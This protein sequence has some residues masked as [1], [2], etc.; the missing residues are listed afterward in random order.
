MALYGSQLKPSGTMSSNIFQRRLNIVDFVTKHGPQTLAQIAKRLGVSLSSVWRHKKAIEPLQRDPVSAFW[1]TTVG[2]KYLVQVFVAVIYCFGIKQGV[3][4]ERLSEFFRLVGLEGHVATSPSALRDFKQQLIEHIN[5]YGKEQGQAKIPENKPLIGGADETFFE[6]PILVL[7]ELASGYIF[8]EV[9][10]EKRSFE[11][12]TE[13]VEKV[14]LPPMTA[15]VSDGARAL[16]KLAIDRLRCIHLPDLFHLLRDL[17]QPWVSFLG[18]ERKHL[19]RIAEELKTRQSQHRNPKQETAYQQRVQDHQR[20]HQAFEQRA[21]SYQQA[22]HRISTAI[23]PFQVE[24]GEWQW[25]EDLEQCLEE[26][27]RQMEALAQEIQLHKAIGQIETFRLHI[28]SLAQ[29][30][31]LWWKGVLQDLEQRTQEPLLQAWA[32]G[33]LLPFVYWEQQAQKTRTSE[34]KAIYQQ[35]AQQAKNALEADIPVQ[36]DDYQIWLLWARQ[37]CAYFQRTSSAIEGRNGALSRLHC[38]S[39]GFSP[40]RLNA[41]TI[42]HNF[43]VRRA[44]GA[45]P[46]ERLFEREFPPLFHWLIGQVQHLP[47]PRKSKKAQR[48]QSSRTLVFSA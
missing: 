12:W 24:N 41:L 19:E 48:L 28:P 11:S 6:Q 7:M 31:N 26:P 43:D 42:I 34:L 40:P 35:A 2:M 27:L 3:G 10:K 4:G 30:V 21:Q 9:E 44:D 13:E 37:Q 25:R 32:I 23:H 15:M 1:S 8:V 45:T 16:I 39:R 17:G 38:A 33:R 20:D 18:K 29:G 47:L 5:Q 14:N 46:A 36:T 22:M